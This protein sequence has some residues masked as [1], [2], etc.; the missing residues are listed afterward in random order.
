L[1]LRKKRSRH[2]GRRRGPQTGARFRPRLEVLEDRTLLSTFTVINVAD[3]GAGS[4]RQAILDANAHPGADLINFNIGSG[5]QTIHVGSTTGLALPAIADTVV[6]DGTSQPGFA[7]TPL[8]EL[9]G[10]NAGAASNGVVVAA[11]N[12]TLQGLVINRFSASGIVL[13][14]GSGNVVVGNYLGTDTS[15]SVALGN[16]IN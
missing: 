14:A 3:S 11:A 2:G 7:G 15:G 13:Q 9:D 16:T 12:C 8:I 4:L 10:T 5:V 1:W 6:I